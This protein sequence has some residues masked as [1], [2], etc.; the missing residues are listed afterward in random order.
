MPRGDGH[1]ASR[2]LLHPSR[3]FASSPPPPVDRHRDTT[4][5]VVHERTHA[6]SGSTR[7][8]LHFDPIR[9]IRSDPTRIPTPR[10]RHHDTITSAAERRT[11]YSTPSLHSSREA[12]PRLC[13]PSIAAHTT[14]PALGHRRRPHRRL[15]WTRPGIQRTTRDGTQPR[16]PHEGAMPVAII[17]RRTGGPPSTTPHSL[18]RDKLSLPPPAWTILVTT[19]HHRV[20]RASPWK[21]DRLK[22]RLK[23]RITAT[24]SRR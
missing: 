2:L 16:R 1:L 21:K 11:P 8:D 18:P 24:P 19:S 9:S 23:G 12:R 22:V 13:R 14:P 6:R 10:R 15:R 4:P 3:S 20:L 17:T 5:T 7:R